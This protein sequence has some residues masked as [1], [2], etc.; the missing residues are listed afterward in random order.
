MPETKVHLPNIM[1]KLMIILLI[2]TELAVFGQKS[3]PSVSRWKSG[4]EFPDSISGFDKKSGIEWTLMNDSGYLYLKYNTSDRYIQ[5]VLMYDGFKL[6]FDTVKQKDVRNCLVYSNKPKGPE[7]SKKPKISEK[8]YSH[9]EE[10]GEFPRTEIKGNF[11]K[12]VWQNIPY[13]LVLEKT[14]F[15]AS[16][17]QD[18]NNKLSCIAVIPFRII[19]K[20]GLNS[21]NKLSVGLEIISRP[22]PSD[23]QAI[24]PSNAGGNNFPS[25]NMPPQGRLQGNSG[26]PDGDRP[27]PPSANPLKSFARFWFLTILAYYP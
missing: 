17:T 9:R 11:N 16:Y 26:H 1:K 8:D 4:E 2:L 20:K 13:D 18:T 22:K 27:G 15:S 23:M 14:E 25:G 19:S 5:N 12:A 3:K 10:P 7:N 24:G 6:Y 21:I